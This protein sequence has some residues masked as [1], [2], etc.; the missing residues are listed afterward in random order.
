[1]SDSMGKEVYEAARD[2]KEAELKRL[3]ERGGSVNWH[4]PEVRRRMCLAWARAP[5]RAL[6][7]R[8]RHR[9]MAR[10]D[11]VS[12]RQPRCTA[13]LGV[14]FDAAPPTRG[15]WHTPPRRTGRA[16]RPLAPVSSPFTS[17]DLNRHSGQI[18]QP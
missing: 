13:R 1:M 7:L 5:S 12:P 3:I 9:G 6:L 18:A 14:G 17:S 16:A 15:A 11:A 4:N 10:H 8:F 2:G